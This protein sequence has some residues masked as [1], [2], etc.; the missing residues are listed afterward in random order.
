[1]RFVTGV[2]KYQACR[3]TFSIIGKITIAIR[4]VHWET[5]ANKRCFSGRKSVIF[6][7]NIHLTL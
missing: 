6:L 3:R 1:M 4:H 7:R 2:I 5:I